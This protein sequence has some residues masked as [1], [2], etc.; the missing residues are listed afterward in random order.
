MLDGFEAFARG[1][2]DVGRR[3]VVLEVDELLGARAAASGPPASHSGISASSAVDA[4]RGTGSAVE[5]ES[6]RRWR[7][8]RQR[9]LPAP[10]RDTGRTRRPP[11]PRW[12]R[13]ARFCR[14]RS[15]PCA[16]AT[17]A[18]RRIARCRCSTGLRPPDI[19]SR[20]HGKVATRP[21]DW[22]L[23]YACTSTDATRR[24]PCAAITT[25]PAIT[26]TPRR[27]AA[28][29]RMPST[30]ARASTTTTRAPQSARSM[31]A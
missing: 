2:Q 7:L 12:P 20:S 27:R 4:A 13:P 31:A 11:P 10:A 16:P 15:R 6:R 25:A 5:T 24:L 29:G 14:A 19:A 23:A 3:H 17:A 1:Q 9:G 26:V 22:P 28:S 30:G 8:R 18:C 21:P